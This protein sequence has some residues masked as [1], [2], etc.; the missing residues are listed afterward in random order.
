LEAEEDWDIWFI[1]GPTVPALLSKMKAYQR[2]NHFPGMYALARKNL[3]AKNLIAMQKYFAR[4]YNFF[5]KTWLLPGDIKP[6]KEQFNHRKAKTFIVK[7]EASCQGKGIFLTRNFD[8]YQVGEHY[9]AQRYLHK[10]FLIDD[11]KFDLR[12]YVLITSVIPL[13]IFIYKEGL[14]R[15]ATTAYVSPLGSNLNN[16]FMHLTNYAINKESEDFQQN[17]GN[18]DA[19]HKRSLSSIFKSIDQAR[20]SDPDIIS[21]QECWQLLKELTVKTIIAGHNHIAHIQRTAKPQDLENQLCFQVLGIDVFIDKKG[22]PWLIEVNQSPSFMTDSPLDHKI[23]FGVLRDSF[24]MLNLSWRRKNRYIN[25]AKIDK[26]R[27]L[28]G[29]PRASNYEKEEIRQKK[30]RIKD[31]FELNNLGGYERIY[32]LQAEHLRDN[33]YNIALQDRYDELIFHSKDIWAESAAGGFSKKKIE[34]ESKPLTKSPEMK[35]SK[36]V[37]KKESANN[38]LCS[39]KKTV[40]KLNSISAKDTQQANSFAQI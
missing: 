38:T 26:Q 8:W 30:I 1:D 13:R 27:R 11:L 39:V 24:R 19:G 10:P 16:L 5:P 33:E 23:K 4:D 35:L 29:L 32:P 40:L 15:F 17:T 18:D 9:V 28:Q 12:I 22:K 6:F 21:S 3:L 31:K 7:P 2:T 25:N 34:P 14:A 20:L 37:S 36:E